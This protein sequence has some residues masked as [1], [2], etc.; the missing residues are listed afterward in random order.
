[1][2][3]QI[4]RSALAEGQRR[5]PG[6]QITA[7]ELGD[8]LDRMGVRSEDVAARAGDLYLAAS[9]VLGDSRAMEHF[10]RVHLDQIGALVARF[11]LDA[12]QLA[13]LRQELRILLFAAPRPR[14]LTYAG[15][16]PLGGWLRVVALRAVMEM[17]DKEAR[18]KPTPEG[19]EALA[20]AIAGFTAP[21]VVAERNVLV[22]AFKKALEQAIDALT[23]QERTVLR[24]H[25]M[26][27]HNIDTIG[28]VF[29]VHRATVARWIVTIRS[30]LFA[31]VRKGL[32]LD[33]APSS[34][35]VRSLFRLLQSDLQVSME[36]LLRSKPQS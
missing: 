18:G 5:F 22:P 35:E 24:L 2:D 12:A 10:E 26:D 19:E 31:H 15:R 36:R 30:Q 6:I 28:R 3:E 14:L 34:T 20:W 4:T 27:H 8:T 23:A 32:G 1:L 21:D 9:C 13:G 33:L 7:A 25:F 17:L 11:R 16:A 29:Q